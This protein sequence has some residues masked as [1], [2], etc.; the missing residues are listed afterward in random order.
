[1]K[2]IMLLML[3]PVSVLAQKGYVVSGSMSGLKTPAIAYLSYGRGAEAF[4]DSAAIK[5]G[6]FQFKGSV[7]MPVQVFLSVKRRNTVD[8]VNKS[9][10]CVFFLENSSISVTAADSIKYAVIKGSV[11]EQENRE[12]E[13]VIRPQ[14]DAIIRLNDEFR[15]KPKDEAY[16]KASDSVTYLVAKN[17]EVRR[18]F[19]VSHLNS[20]MG[21]Y[22]FH[23][24]VLDSK[25]DP[26]KEEPLFA[27]FS[28]ELKTSELGQQAQEK[29]NVAKKRQTGVAATDFTQ[30]DLHDKPF[31]LSSLR[32]KYVLVDFWASWCAPCR[33][34]NPNVKKAYQELKG[35]NFEIVGVSLD[36]GKGAWAD[37]VEKD[38]LP[39]IH[40]CDLQGWKNA[41]ATMY[42]ITS[43]PQNLLINPQGV[44]IAKNLRGEDLTEKLSALIK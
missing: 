19:V 1:M 7:K 23:Y 44:I 16:K 3:L 27:R 36:Q 11:A 22:H 14:T 21:L 43:V 25:F 34:E 8:V 30:N 4:R 42:G 15:G 5:N 13:A 10:Y 28:E 37:A 40:V 6:R 29:I 9:D 41:V 18:E 32:G 35:K 2:K 26:A 31:T 12:A 39:W 24:F 17:R 33:A 38:G 20:F